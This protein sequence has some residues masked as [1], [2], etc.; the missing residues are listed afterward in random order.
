M[1]LADIASASDG[2]NVQIKAKFTNQMV[3]TIDIP[4]V[5]PALPFFLFVTSWATPQT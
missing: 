5:A 2:F 1:G 4:T 3:G